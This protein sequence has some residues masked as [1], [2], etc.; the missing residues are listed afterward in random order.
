MGPDNPQYG[1]TYAFYLHRA[2]RLDQALQ[3]IR[4]VRERHPAHQDSAMLEQAL[5]RNRSQRRRGNQSDSEGESVV[6]GRT[7]AVSLSPMRQH[8][9]SPQAD[10]RSFH[11]R[12]PTW[13]VVALLWA[14]ALA[15]LPG[16]SLL[17][18]PEK[19]VSAVVPAGQSK[20]PD[21]LQMQLQVQRF[22][23]DFAARTT[24]AL[25][26]YAQRV[27]TE[28]ARVQALRLKLTGVTAVI[29]IASGPNPR[30][31]LMDLVA[32]ATLTRMTVE[33]HWLRTTNGEAFQPWL[34]A[35]RELETNAW[36]LAAIVFKPAQVEEL[37][38]AIT[39]WRAQ[40]PRAFS[41]FY[42]RPGEFAALVRTSAGKEKDV[43][44]IF[45][46]VG[47][48]PTT[49]LDPAVREVTRT[50]LFAERAM[51]TLQL[52][53]TLVR[54]QTELLAFELADQP[55]AKQ[56][57]SDADRFTRSTEVF[58]KTA[59]TLPKLVNDQREA[60]IQQLL[61]G[62]ATERSNI[63]ASLYSEEKK[64]RDLL[65][66]TRSTLNA[67][68]E[69]ATSLNAAIKSLDT[70]VRYVSPPSTNTAPEPVDTNS[71]PFNVLDYGKAASQVGGMAKDLTGL[72]TSVN[73]SV[74]QLAKIGEQAGADAKEVVHRAFWLG[75]LLIVILLAG[76]VLAGL[77]YRI[78]ADKLKRRGDPP[79]AVGL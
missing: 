3:A 52:M 54:W 28:P 65:A 74:P 64:A 13:K 39:D 37:R 17:R 71:P 6:T 41:A 40:N 48:D 47:L 79:S 70:F 73:Q 59:E 9:R 33:E 25:D 45:G 8:Q 44:S 53:P 31:N 32:V 55:A 11:G 16:C 26:E 60:A 21:P 63:L 23:E 61:A 62:V 29:S 2:G 57:L 50:R 24:K 35:S 18:A 30:A 1:Y 67:G 7:N 51:F 58:A 69:M 42:A 4:S 76:S 46:L 15:L 43:N 68:S 38:K 49:G 75:L 78:L 66:E 10:F 27:G 20:E 5:L 34:D 19:M 22:T 12:L 56:V 77:A 36:N 72:L 14:G